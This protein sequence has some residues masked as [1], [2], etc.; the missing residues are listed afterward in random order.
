[1]AIGKRSQSKRQAHLAEY[2]GHPRAVCPLISI[3]CLGTHSR[4]PDTEQIVCLGSPL[5]GIY[6]FGYYSVA[7]S[8]ETK[9]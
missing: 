1:M 5:L 3:P 7:L 9:A 8:T 6:C 4:C 2:D